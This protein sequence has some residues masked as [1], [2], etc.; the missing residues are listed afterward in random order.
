MKKN[1]FHTH[2]FF[3][4]AAVTPDQWSL[5]DENRTCGIKTRVTGLYW[6]VRTAAAAIESK[7]NSHCHVFVSLTGLDWTR[8]DSV[9]VYAP[10]APTSVT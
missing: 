7:L 9:G 2:F 6:C 8:L 4:T 10:C 5:T 3:N 1:K